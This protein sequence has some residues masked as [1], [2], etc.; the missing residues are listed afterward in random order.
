M[1]DF[2]ASI[3][4]M[5]TIYITF[6]RSLL[7]QSCQVWH[8]S[9]TKENSEAIERVQKCAVKCILQGRYTS[10]KQALSV[11]DIPTC[12]DRRTALNLSFARKCLNNPKMKHLFPLNENSS[13]MT[14]N[15]EKYKVVQANTQ[16]DWLVQA[17]Y[18]CRIY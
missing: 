8:S 6:I 12:K 14:R 7:E 13:M 18:S 11:L 16:R 4:D 1:S 3:E 10:Y 15:R 17:L 9:L 5:K 2:N